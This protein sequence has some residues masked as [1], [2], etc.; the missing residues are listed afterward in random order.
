LSS[1][2]ETASS[3][4]RIYGTT[5][6]AILIE[7]EGGEY[8][9]KFRGEAPTTVESPFDDVTI[10]AL[11]AIT[12]VEELAGRKITENGKIIG[13]FSTADALNYPKCLMPA[14]RRHRLSVSILSLS[15]F[16]SKRM[17]G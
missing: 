10:G 5:T 16:S 14:V 11:N 2:G 17:T 3:I 8:R 7:K 6:K 4:A 15:F 12:E 13:I 9:L 1:P